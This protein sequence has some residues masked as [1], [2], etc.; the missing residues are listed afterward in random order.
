MPNPYQQ[1][2]N[3]E[4]QKDSEFE[5]IAAKSDELALA[6]HKQLA[7]DGMLTGHGEHDLD[8][9]DLFALIETS[10]H[11]D[12]MGVLYDLAYTEVSE[13]LARYTNTHLNW[14]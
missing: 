7:E 3:L 8:W 4:S 6:Y 2:D 11:D 5:L 1:Q 14:D 10:K 12:V 9:P 13:N